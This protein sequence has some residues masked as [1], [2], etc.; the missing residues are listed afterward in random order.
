MPTFRLD[1]SVKA[2][3]EA[4]KYVCKIKWSFKNKLVAKCKPCEVSWWFLLLWDFEASRDRQC[5]WLCLVCKKPLSQWFVAD[6]TRKSLGTFFAFLGKNI[7][8]KLFQH[9]SKLFEA[10]FCFETRS[11]KLM[12]T[13]PKRESHSCQIAP[14]V[15]DNRKIPPD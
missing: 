5:L 12:I 14:F 2:F 15:V 7:Y 10:N 11:Q 3:G 1:Q 8:S 9:I 4:G 13:N 6:K